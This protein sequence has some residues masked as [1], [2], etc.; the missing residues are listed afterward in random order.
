[1]L[2]HYTVPYYLGLIFGQV[3][4]SYKVTQDGIVF[5]F[6]RVR[7]LFCI[8]IF[9]VLFICTISML[10]MGCT[11]YVLSTFL[12]SMDLISFLMA[13]FICQTNNIY[14]S[15]NLSNIL[16]QLYDLER[17]KKPRQENV[18]VYIAFYFFELLLLVI[19][20]LSIPFFAS[21]TMSLPS[22]CLFAICLTYAAC[23]IILATT[24]F[25]FFELRTHI[26]QWRHSLVSKKN[27]F[28]DLLNCSKTIKKFEKIFIEANKIYQIPI[29]VLL[30]I[31]FVNILECFYLCLHYR[32]LG[33]P[34]EDLGTN[35]L[36]LNSPILWFLQGCV[37]CVYMV[38]YIDSCGTELRKL[39]DKIGH[40]L[41]AEQ[42][43]DR[44]VIS[45][46]AKMHF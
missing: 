24:F 46:L 16:K 14:Y 10:F 4:F 29:A 43:D 18:F 21:F 45:L 33:S 26:T 42:F 9:A 38:Y 11:Y 2:K 22:L 31:S 35:I 7:L 20:L 3:P 13:W 25:I 39:S 44:K 17:K 23:K 32:Y 28:A 15:K 12:S 41:E 8:L 5:S 40:M 27:T 34:F 6:T 30:G 36:I 19:L 1:M 37:D